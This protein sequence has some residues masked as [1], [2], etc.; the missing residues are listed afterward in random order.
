MRPSL[1]FLALAVFGWAGVRGPRRSALF[2]VPT[3]SRLS[4][5]EAKPPPLVPTEFPAIEPVAPAAP[6]VPADYPHDA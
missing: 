5:S 4:A 3:S 6:V 2:P 1:R